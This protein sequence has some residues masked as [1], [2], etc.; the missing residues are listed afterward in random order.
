MYS[1]NDLPG[2][3]TKTAQEFFPEDCREGFRVKENTFFGL[4]GYIFQ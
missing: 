3:K 1:I 4:Y 2:I